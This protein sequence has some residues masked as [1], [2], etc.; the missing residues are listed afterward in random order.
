MKNYI[1]IVFI[2]SLIISTTLIK[3]STKDL[4]YK[5][6]DTQE[7]IG[8]LKEEMQMLRLEHDY[9]TSPQKLLEY[10]H[11]YFEED[12]KQKKIENFNSIYIDDNKFSIREFNFLKNEK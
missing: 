7:D 2:T 11:M 5:L 4:E 1:K 10:K 3:K 9:L 6:Y 8:L 12:L